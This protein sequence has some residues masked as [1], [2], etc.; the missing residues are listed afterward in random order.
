MS[1]N[2]IIGYD[3]F[4]NE[5]FLLCQSMILTTSIFARDS[6]VLLTTIENI[7]SVLPQLEYNC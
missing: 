7:Q 4:T 2:M 6:T 5:H 3:C 1:H